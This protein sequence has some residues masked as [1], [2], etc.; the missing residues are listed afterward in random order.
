MPA[1]TY[2]LELNLEAESTDDTV[3][4]TLVRDVPRHRY[5]ALALLLLSAPPFF[6]WALKNPV[7]KD[8]GGEDHFSVPFM[9]VIG[10]AFLIFQAWP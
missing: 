4:V 8:S 7:E 10:Y 6:L 9:L 3:Q 2:R 5:L 1:G